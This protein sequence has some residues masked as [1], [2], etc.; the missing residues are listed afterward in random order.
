MMLMKLDSQEWAISS[1]PELLVGLLALLVAIHIASKSSQAW[2]SPNTTS[3][4]RKM[5]RGTVSSEAVRVELKSLP[6]G[7]V[8]LKQ[9]PFGQMLTRRDKAARY[10]QEVTPGLD[11]KDISRIQID[12]LNEASRLYDFSHCIADHNIEDEDGN[13]LDFSDK[14][15]AMTL[16]VLD[17]KI[18]AEIE[19]EIDKLNRD[20]TDVE[21]FTMPSGA[22]STETGKE[23]QK[24]TDTV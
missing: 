24:D 18:G 23:S 16:Q 3:R 14:M 22:S 6:G 4:E 9:L 1:W 10:L 20:D 15:V 12:V 8:M 19:R 2:I 11:G 21:G 17:P 5:P 13:K 7:F